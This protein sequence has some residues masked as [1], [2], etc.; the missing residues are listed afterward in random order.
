M[1]LVETESVVLKTHDLAEA[2]RIIVLLTRDHG[3]VRG[4]AK[5][6]KRLK[7]RFGSAFEPFSIV[8]VEY[9]QKDSVELVALQKAEI[10]RSSFAAAGDPDF[11]RK[12][13]YLGDLLISFLPPHDPNEKVYRMTRACIEVAAAGAGSLLPVGVYFEL[14]LLRLAG[15]MP[16]WSRCRDCRRELDADEAADLLADLHVLCTRC[17]RAASNRTLHP[18]ARGVAEAARIMAPGVFSLE[19]AGREA[20]LV[21]LSAMLRLLISSALGREVAGE[22]PLPLHT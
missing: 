12:F 4:V 18:E 20:D 15:Y 22:M 7:S 14:W 1:P 8:R 13:S 16:D 21:H 11:L 5:G 19:M 10:V 2:D 17:G 3:L 6:V 9:F